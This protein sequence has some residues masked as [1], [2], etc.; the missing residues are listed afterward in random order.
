MFMT[1]KKLVAAT[2]EIVR[3]HAPLILKELG[4][5]TDND[6]ILNRIL[7]SPGLPTE[8]E[9]EGSAGIFEFDVNVTRSNV[10]HIATGRQYVRGTGVI[11][12]YP[13]NNLY[14][15]TNERKRKKIPCSSLLST[16]AQVPLKKQ[17]IEQLAH[18]LRHYWQYVTGIGFERSVYGQDG[19]HVLKYDNRWV[20]RDANEFA[21]K[22]VRS[23]K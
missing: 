17:I 16:V 18:E 1:N 4:L 19:N 2:E 6:D 21:A 20:E 7:V 12:M 9:Q 14:Y 13:L 10:F 5:D 22:Y 15:A 3:V 8:K 11:T 23:L